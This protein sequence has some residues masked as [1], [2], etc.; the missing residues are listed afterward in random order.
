MCAEESNSGQEHGHQGSE[1]FLCPNIM[2]KA[3]S[4]SMKGE[5]NK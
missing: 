3:K 4:G 5:S 2:E 1:E